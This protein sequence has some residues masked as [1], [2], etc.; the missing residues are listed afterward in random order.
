MIVVGIDPGIEVSHGVTLSSAPGPAT[1]Y[2]TRARLLNT[3][4]STPE[5]LTIWAAEQRA[6]LILVE[7]ARGSVASGRDNDP[8]LHINI[9]AGEILGRL[10]A[11]GLP[12]APVAS[13]GAVTAW[14]WRTMIGVT[15]SGAD[16][17]D[18]AITGIV[19]LRLDNHDEIPT[20]SR[21]GHLGHYWDA[22]GIALGGMDRAAQ[23]PTLTPL[24]AALHV[25]PIEQARLTGLRA[26]K[27][28]RKLKR[29]GARA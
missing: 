26:S 22:S 9:V 12:A 5:H 14:N 29:Q 10:R 23:L 25:T 11:A 21:G 27:Q 2:G 18:D 1:A 4:A 8:V 6:H 13:G 19:R 16:V 17:R 3:I 15:G 20:G 24:G 7:V 28:A